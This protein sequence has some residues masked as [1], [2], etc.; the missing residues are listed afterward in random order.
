[1]RPRRSIAVRPGPP[2]PRRHGRHRRG[3]PRA[4]VAVGGGRHRS[5]VEPDLGRLAV[6][7]ARSSTRPGSSCCPAWST[8]TPTPG[9]R[10]TRSRIGSS[11]TRSRRRSAARRRSSRSTTR[12]RARRRRRSDRCWPGCGS[13]GRDRA[14]IAIDYA[15][16]LAISGRMDDPIAELPAMVD[17]GVPTAKAF[18]V[19]DFRLDERRIF[20]A[21]R[22]LGSRGGMLQVHCEDPVLI[23]T[24]VADALA[25]GDTAP[26]STPTTRSRRGGGR[27]DPPRHGLRA[28]GGRAGPRRP[29]LV[30]G[31]ASARPRGAKARGVRAHAETCPHYLALT[32]ARY[33]SPD[34][35]SVRASA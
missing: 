19:F 28:R 6:G 9:S 35:A 17:E 32:D 24:A 20:E 34:L 7:A 1:M 13:G 31:R 22:V 33:A 11:R 25:R 3:S 16:S 2:R 26:R 15:V 23:D 30:R 5:A 27:R 8:S 18:M 21:M 12:A 14:D 10:P 29:S 4:D